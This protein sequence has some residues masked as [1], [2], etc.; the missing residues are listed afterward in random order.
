[1]HTALLRPFVYVY[2]EYAIGTCDRLL[3]C[4]VAGRLYRNTS[5]VYVFIFVFFFRLLQLFYCSRMWELR[6][7]MHTMYIQTR[8]YNNIEACA[9]FENQLLLLLNYITVAR[10][11]TASYAGPLLLCAC[12]PLC[13]NRQ[14]DWIKTRVCLFQ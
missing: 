7:C 12:V 10:A 13:Q 1:M 5:Y 3:S 8:Q 6:A 14:C 4:F 9:F 2:G 11:S